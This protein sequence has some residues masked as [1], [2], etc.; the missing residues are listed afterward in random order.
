M[1][2]FV[3]LISFS[4]FLELPI[5]IEFLELLRSMNVIISLLHLLSKPSKRKRKS[6]ERGTVD[7]YEEGMYQYKF[8]LYLQWVTR[9]F[10]P[11]SDWISGP[12]GS[13]QGDWICPKCENVNFAFRTI[14]NIKK[15]GAA[16]PSPVSV[17]YKWLINCSDIPMFTMINF[18]T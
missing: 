7:L 10:K 8:I 18:V 11:I 17:S 2:A 4:T 5:V 14:C 1:L 9:S 12:D 6:K 16:R 15:C 13:Y 3:M